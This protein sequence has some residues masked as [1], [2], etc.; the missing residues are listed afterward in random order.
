MA[1]ASTLDMSGQSCNFPDDFRLSGGDDFS[2]PTKARALALA[3]LNLLAYPSCSRQE[4]KWGESSKCLYPAATMGYIWEQNDSIYGTNITDSA[5][6]VTCQQALYDTCQ[7][8][9]T[10]FGGQWNRISIPWESAEFSFGVEAYEY[11]T[12]DTTVLVFRGTF[13]PGDHANMENLMMDFLL[14][15]STSRMKQAWIQDAGLAWSNE[16][17][18]RFEAAEDSFYKLLIRTAESYVLGQ[19]RPLKE[20]FSPRNSSLA[21][22]LTAAVQRNESLRINLA[23]FTE[24]EALSTG[25]WAITRYIAEKAHERAMLERNHTLI[26][27]GHSQGGTRAQLASMYLHHQTN[28]KHPTVTFAA[29]G[30]ECAAQMLFAK[31]ANILDDVDVFVAHEHMQE[32]VH[33]LDPWG[34]SMLGVDVS[35]GQTCFWGKVK[36]SPKGDTHLTNIETTADRYCSH[37]YGYSG[38]VLIA[39]EAD[40]LAR[41]VDH[42]LKHQ[43]RRCRYYTHAMESILI[44]L[45]DELLDDGT[46]LSGCSADLDLSYDPGQCP[47]GKITFEEESIALA[48]V[49]GISISILGLC[50]CVC[51]FYRR[52]RNYR[53]VNGAHRLSVQEDEEPSLVEND[54][55]DSFELP[56]IT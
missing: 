9:A 10:Q 19:D 39:A 44:N 25:Y 35:G 23:N 7:D 42:E 8:W 31:R 12:E 13:G 5:A 40:M 20:A 41:D 47:V 29:T 6:E 16:M 14:E 33:P 21:F 28:I 52:R 53:Y 18:Q 34:N 1:R 50:I 43:F 22:E 51:L 37:V 15:R 27:T 49:F 24:E 48:L 17:G 54:I 55:E 3:R 56:K 38:P 36:S 46:T 32:Y 11:V 2:K 30:S 26:I 45:G 4:S